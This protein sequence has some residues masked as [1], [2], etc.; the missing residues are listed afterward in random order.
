MKVVRDIS[1]LTAT[2]SAILAIGTFDGVH[3]GHQYLLCQAADRARALGFQ[4][5]VITFD[6]LPAVVLRPEAAPP[7]LTDAHEKIELIARLGIDICIVQHFTSEFAQLSADQFLTLVLAHID[8]REIWMGT[9]FAFGHNREGD[10]QYLSRAANTLGFA[11]HIIPRQRL[12]GI[13]ISSTQ[14][15]EL[16]LGGDIR[17]ATNLLGYY[18][19]LSGTVVH[20]AGR[21][22]PLGYPTANIAPAPRHIIPPP[23][24]YAGYT[25][26]ADDRYPS[27]ISIGHN[28]T[29]GH[30]PLSV[31]SHI[32]D[33]DGELWGQRLTLEF[34][35]RTRDEITFDSVEA[36]VQR[37]D[38]DVVEI[39]EVLAL[40]Q[41]RSVLKLACQR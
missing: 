13:P 16:L 17:G 1:E 4:S 7:Q 21:G 18:P 2:K 3:R 40:A 28:P 20:G 25:R 12:N 41:E 39:R 10:V 33:F 5:I 15:R 35:E 24:V 27:A 37:M 38:R 19:L 30:N 36:L 14:I 22:R 32:L 29:F 11:L 31:E 6:P 8:V 26:I 34:V 23:G 9:D